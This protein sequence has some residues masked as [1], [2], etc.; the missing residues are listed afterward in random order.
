MRLIRR[1]GVC[2]VLLSVMA[3]AS[4]RGDAGVPATPPD[5]PCDPSSLVQASLYSYRFETM[6]LRH[7]DLLRLRDGSLH[8]GKVME[9]ATQIVL[10]DQAG[11]RRAYDVSAVEEFVGRRRA[12][13]LRRPDRPDLTVAYVERLPRDRQY[14][15]RVRT[16]DGLPVLADG[17]EAG[18]GPP[19]PG[20]AVTF[21]IHVLNAGGAGAWESTCVVTLDGTEVARKDVPALKVGASHVVEIP[22][23]W[24]SGNPVLRVTLEPGK[25]TREIVRWNN[26]LETRIGSQAL[27]VIV[28]RDRYERF[29]SVRNIVDSFCIEDWIRYHVRVLNALLAGS[30]HASSPNGV[31]ERVRFDRLLVVD[32][33]G[34]V[35][36]PTDRA[37]SVALSP[38]GGGVDA[39]LA[40]ADAAGHVDWG[41]IQGM[42][43]DLGLADLTTAD[44]T[45]E[46]CFVRDEYGV[47]VNRRYLSPTLGFMM[48]HAGGFPFTEPEAAYLNK[49]RGRPRGVRG[50]YLWQVPASIVVEPRSNDGQPLGGVEIAMFQRMADEEGVGRVTGSGP[51]EPLFAGTTG[52]RGRLALPNQPAPT[53]TSPGGYTLRPNPFGKIALDGS[54]GLL[55]LRLSH[56]GATEYHFLSL[57][58]CNVAYLRGHVREYVHRIP[59]RFGPLDAPPAPTGVAMRTRDG[60]TSDRPEIYLHWRAP[61]TGNAGAIEEF[62]I[63]RRTSF[64]GNGAKPWMLHSVFDPAVAKWQ[65]DADVTCYEEHRYDGP[66]SLD[67]R[68]A[69]SAV[70]HLGRESG[71]S[72]VSAFV[73]HDKVN[74]KFAIDPDHQACITLRGPGAAG[75]LQYNGRAG[76][77][78]YGLR[79][80]KFPGYAP[81]FGGVAITA[82]RHLLITDP[83]NHVLAVYDRGD[84]LSVIPPRTN[85]PGLPGADDGEFNGPADV[86]VDLQHRLYV[87][88]QGNNRVQILDADGSFHGI[89]DPETAFEG[90]A[91]VGFANGR[92]C[93]T[94]RK[95]RRVRVYDVSGA[96]PV[97][98]CELPP[99]AD[100]DRALVSAAGRIYVTGRDE[101]SGKW[102][103]LVYKAD[104]AG[105]K[106]VEALTRAQ[107]QNG[108]IREPRGLYL[109][110]SGSDQYG[111][112][113]NGL[114][115]NVRRIQLDA[116]DVEPTVPQL[117]GS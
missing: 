70:D 46:R 76:T 116:M 3:S 83:E 26:T 74:A 81:A 99:L 42:A 15:H 24:Q 75:V 100:A 32:D 93:V 110:Q 52:I 23:T 20:A 68:F 56:L 51:G 33:P 91:C 17:S 77:Q 38:L 7:M 67:T 111:Y 18:A 31:A 49:M 28:A 53:H 104:D 114:P 59:T 101:T 62:R 30:V 94:D 113:V 61:A 88:D 107:G 79:H 106:L 55:L 117:S 14:R 8:V 50:E 69:V 16:V 64:G 73:A 103:V 84:L 39:I 45:I 96:S 72:T 10:F 48:H 4:T 19:S 65:L 11:Q 97:F 108:D 22:W 25:G 21:Q 98:V 40:A 89:L 60:A 102:A 58:D 47:Y 29:R 86:A 44:T 105:I 1:V 80:P 109:Y 85:W 6:H 34:I 27:T 13:Q 63:Y 37:I 36:W 95:G 41:L 87:A 90:P 112:F 43:R 92:L 12:R 78:P 35:S 9:W 54:N 115:Y 71:L 57:F 66:Y 5:R 2:G 82:D